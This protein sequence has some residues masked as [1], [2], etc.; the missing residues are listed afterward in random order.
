MRKKR[1]A[2][3]LRLFSDVMYVFGFFLIIPA[4]IAVLLNE[5]PQ[6]ITFAAGV[7]L[8]V[9]LFGFLRHRLKDAIPNKNHAQWRCTVL[10][11]LSLLSSIPFIVNG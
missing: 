3:V 4:M 11:F 1:F 9:P 5:F 8:F 2:A 6:A 7:A 10:L